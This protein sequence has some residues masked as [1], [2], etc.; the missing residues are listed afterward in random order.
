M[1]D[2]CLAGQAVGGKAMPGAHKFLEAEVLA[3]RLT[4]HLLDNLEGGVQ[5]VYGLRL[6]SRQSPHLLNSSS[7]S[8]SP[9]IRDAL[10]LEATRTHRGME[11]VHVS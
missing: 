1:R 4:F 2:S 10:F 11:I 9:L 6:D 8:A 3:G 7:Q 5:A